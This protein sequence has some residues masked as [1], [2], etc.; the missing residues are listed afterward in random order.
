MLPRNAEE[1]RQPKKVAMPKPY[2]I[3]AAALVASGRSLSTVTIATAIDGRALRPTNES[4]EWFADFDRIGSLTFEAPL[5]M[6]LSAERAPANAAT[7]A[8]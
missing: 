5:A 8:A 2:S 7:L 3:L 1:R 6:D 4:Q